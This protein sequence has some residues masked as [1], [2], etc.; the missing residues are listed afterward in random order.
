MYRLVASPESTAGSWEDRFERIFQVLQWSTLAAAATIAFVAIGVDARTASAFVLAGLVAGAYRIAPVRARDGEVAGELLALLGVAAGLAAVALTEGTASP[1]LLFLTVPV[2]HASAFGGTRLGG[3]TALLTIVGLAAVTLTSQGS[4]A[5]PAFVQAV[6]VYALVAL[7]FS[8]ARRVLVEERRRA[9]ELFRAS[10]LDARRLERLEGT[11]QLLVSLSDLAD[12]S[13]LNPVSVGTTAL[14]DLAAVV[15][16]VAAELQVRS[17]RG[18]AVVARRGTAPGPGEPRSFP[19]V[20]GDRRLG[21]LR[22]WPQPDRPLD[23]YR[24][25]V[26]GALRPVALALENAS[27]LRSIAARAVREER[28]RLGRDLHDEIGPGI[29]AVGLGLDV[30]LA[31][32]DLDPGLRSHLESVRSTAT[33]LVDDVRAVVSDLRSEGRGSIVELVRGLAAE[34]PV[35]GPSV[36]VALDERRPPRDAMAS[37]VAGIVVEAFRNAVEHA[38][39]TVLRVEGVVDRDHGEVVVDDDGHGFEP[40]TVPSNRYGLVGM[41]ERATRVGADLEIVSDRR[42][43]TTVRLAWGRT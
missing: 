42:R 16:Y 10:V 2:F 12:A 6:F 11:H 9:A 5:E 32:P 3:A 27:L 8:Q 15:P 1:Y 28:M 38:G 13:E 29:A 31:R 24:D 37:E 43:G 39:A 23:G 19:I 20:L 21:T 22:L 34:V 25:V 36:V 40:A 35:D 30:A 18:A 14:R 41:R 4:L 26:D 7:A 33:R 17:E